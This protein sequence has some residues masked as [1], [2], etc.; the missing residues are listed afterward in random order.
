MSAT[1]VV[2]AAPVSS[3]RLRGHHRKTNGLRERSRS[4]TVRVSVCPVTPAR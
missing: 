2:T 1:D 3:G 4:D